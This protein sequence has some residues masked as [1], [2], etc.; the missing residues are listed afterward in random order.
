M[1]FIIPIKLFTKVK[2]SSIAIEGNVTQTE[3]N[4][5]SAMKNTKEESFFRFWKSSK[6]IQQE[7]NEDLV[8]IV[9]KYK[10]V[11]YRDARIVYDSVKYKK[12]DNT[13]AIKLKIEEGR[14]YYFGNIKFLGNT[15]YTDQG[16]NRVLG[17]KKGETYNGVLLQDRIANKKNPDAEDITN[18]YQNNGYLFSSINP[19]EVRTANDTIDFEIRIME[20][21]L[22]YFNKITVV[23]NVIDLSGSEVG[24][25]AT[26]ANAGIVVDSNSIVS[27][28]IIVGA[29]QD[30]IIIGQNSSATNNS[31]GDF[32]LNGIFCGGINCSVSA[33]IL[34]SAIDSVRAIRSGFANTTAT[35]NRTV[36]TGATTIG[37]SGTGGATNA[38]VVANNFIGTSTSVS[39]VGAGLINANNQV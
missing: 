37:F 28:N 32:T 14:K 3:K 31:V 34:S 33:N 23:G 1:L 19:V 17:I 8:N 39:V 9:N 5:K 20:G 36:L 22:A 15:I 2:I 12:E 21:P 16:L 6:F 13:I 25:V 10:S 11:G 38:T 35:A 24:G 4:V 18:L 29:S 7:Y 27:S 30:G 26:N